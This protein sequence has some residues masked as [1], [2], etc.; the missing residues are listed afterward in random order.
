VQSAHGNLA[1]ICCLRHSGDAACCACYCWAEREC[2]ECPRRQCS[3]GGHCVSWSTCV[4]TD[5][6]D[7]QLVGMVW[8]EEEWY[9][10]Y[11]TEEKINRQRLKGSSSTGISV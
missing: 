11:V 2:R 5:A 10:W 6:V 9:E 4:G 8:E 1:S 7:L 3:A